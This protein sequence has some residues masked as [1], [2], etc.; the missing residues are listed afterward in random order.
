[1][2]DLTDEEK[3]F[4]RDLAV[5]FDSMLDAKDDGATVREV[6]RELKS[7]LI[8]DN[9]DAVFAYLRTNECIDARIEANMR[10]QGV[11]K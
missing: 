2:K 9:K 6:M 4:I 10:M 8:V 11:L 7:P 3:K 5:K 1:M